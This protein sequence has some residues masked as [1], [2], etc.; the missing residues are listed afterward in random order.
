MNKRTKFWIKTLL[1]TSI[2]LVC[3]WY[4]MVLAIFNICMLTPETRQL[5]YYSMAALIIS[6]IIGC[7]VIYIKLIKRWRKHHFS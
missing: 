4:L 6:A 2:T 5:T 3:L 7:I 1:L